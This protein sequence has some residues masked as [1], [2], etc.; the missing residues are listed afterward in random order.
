MNFHLTFNT[1]RS[2]RIVFSKFIKEQIPYDHPKK[3]KKRTSVHLRGGDLSTP[4]FQK[5]VQPRTGCVTEA[6]PKITIARSSLFTRRGLDRVRGVHA[7][8]ALCPLCI[9]LQ[10]KNQLWNHKPQRQMTEHLPSG[11][12]LPWPCHIPQPS[13]SSPKKIR[14]ICPFFFQVGA[15]GR[16]LPLFAQHDLYEKGTHTDEDSRFRAR[17][18][19]E[20]L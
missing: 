10:M 20:A 16:A 7:I 15:V 11:L 2:I 1:R 5:C 12:G 14:C 9:I 19:V 13:P 8:P 4:N 17:Q 6:D 18:A 3:K